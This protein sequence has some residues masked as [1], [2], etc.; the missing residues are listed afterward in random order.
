M[1]ILILGNAE[2]AH[3]AHM[4]AVL[5]KANATVEYLDTQLFPSRIR[6]SWQPCDAGGCIELPSGKKLE[7]QD[8][9]SV[10]WRYFY[11][12]RIPAVGDA[13]QQNI[14]RRDSMTA[15]RSIFQACSARWVNSWQAYQF[16][17]EKPLQL[18]TVKRIGVTIPATYI[19][20]DPQQIIQFAKN[21]GKTIFKPVYG[22]S[23]TRFVTKEHLEIE[24]LHLALKLSPVTL[25]EYIPGTNVRSYVIGDSVYSAEIRTDAVD[26]RDDSSAKIFPVDLPAKIRQ[27]SKKIAS[28]FAL[29]W[30]AIDWRR[31]TTN[32]YVFLEAN[33][34]PMFLYFERQTG[35]PITQELVRLLLG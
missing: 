35:F 11:G 7:L 24:R 10:Y 31:T 25:Q 22:G 20:N 9:H 17:Q 29:K 3:A 27:Q 5:T 4:H 23:H 8:I 12:V 19:G 13:N 14:A 28:T 30:T 1:N 34:S 16:H 33:P 15:V 2:D 6:L 32:K 26:F 18:N 21:Y